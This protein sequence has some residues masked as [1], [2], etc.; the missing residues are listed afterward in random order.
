MGRMCR[1]QCPTQALDLSR[2]RRGSVL[3]SQG[4]LLPSVS[5]RTS[6]CHRP[7][8]P[9]W[10]DSPFLLQTSKR[11]FGAFFFFFFTSNPTYL[12]AT[13]GYWISRTVLSGGVGGRPTASPHTLFGHC[14]LF[15]LGDNVALEKLVSPA[16]QGHR[17][18][19]LVEP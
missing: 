6:A 17:L 16:G 5:V 1:N 7:P 19:S 11:G 2:A 15:E 13:T 10:P 14:T 9:P 3:N 18:L 4:D 8:R 12:P